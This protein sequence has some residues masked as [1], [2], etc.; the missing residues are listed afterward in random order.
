[1]INKLTTHRTDALS[2]L[3]IMSGL[4]FFAHGSQKLLSFP[5]APEWEVAAFSLPWI[6]GVLELLG[7]ALIALGLFT[8][9]TAFV[10][11]GLMAFAYFIAHAPQNF[12]PILNGGESAILFCFTFLYFVFSGPGRLSLDALRG[13]A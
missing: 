1:M 10:L 7:G 8:R 3:R 11:S 4:L 12:Y 9:P 5:A 13:R 6:A 2:A